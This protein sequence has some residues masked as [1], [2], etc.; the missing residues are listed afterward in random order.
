MPESLTCDTCTFMKLFYKL[1]ILLERNMAFIS[2]DR[3]MTSFDKPQAGISFSCALL[4]IFFGKIQQSDY[5][6]IKPFFK[7]NHKVLPARFL[8][9]P[10]CM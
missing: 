6:Y 9:I 2:F 3:M 5:Y 10:S 4:L 7:K 1:I 8:F